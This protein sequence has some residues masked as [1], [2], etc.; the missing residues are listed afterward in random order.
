MKYVQNFKMRKVGV[1]DVEKLEAAPSTSG[2]CAEQTKD[3]VEHTVDT[4]SGSNN[5]N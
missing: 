4:A 3:C 1:R 5:V 2:T